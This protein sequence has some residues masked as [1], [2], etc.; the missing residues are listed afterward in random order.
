MESPRCAGA[1]GPFWVRQPRKGGAAPARLPAETLPIGSTAFADDARSCDE[2][3][4]PPAIWVGGT[5]ND[6]TLPEGSAGAF[7]ILRLDGAPRNPCIRSGGGGFTRNHP[8]RAA[9]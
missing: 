8:L 3:G 4:A 2:V 1:P 6:V 9:A 5:S 7:P